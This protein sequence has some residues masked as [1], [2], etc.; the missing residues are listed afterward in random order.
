[1]SDAGTRDVQ[2]TVQGAEDYVRGFVRGLLIGEH[3]MWWP[4]FNQEFGIQDETLAETLKEWVGLS[5]PMTRFIMP[6]AAVPMLRH[7]LADPRSVGIAVREV[8]PILGSSFEFSLAIFNE[9]IGQQANDIFSKVPPGVNIVGFTPVESVN[10][11]ATGVELYSPA[12]DYSLKG[13]GSVSGPF[14]DVLYVHEQA[15][16]LSQQVKESRLALEL[17]PPI[18]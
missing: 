13:K 16:R 15:R 5:E 1:M 14:R 11:D 2:V 7:A 10:P 4:I 9:A 12:H 8:R 3:T 6:E 18:E 17:G